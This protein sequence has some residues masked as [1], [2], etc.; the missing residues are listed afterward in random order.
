MQYKLPQIAKMAKGTLTGN[1]NLRVTILLTDSRKLHHPEGVLFIAIRGATDGHNYIRQMLNS[2]VKTFLVEYWPEYLNLPPDAARIKVENTVTALQNIAKEH[3]KQ[4]NIPIIGITG[5]NG[6]TIVKEWISHCLQPEMQVTRNPKSY[7]SQIGV[8]LSVWELS[9]R[10]EIGI[11]EAGISQ[12]CEMELIEAVIAPTIGVFTNIG[13]AHQENFNDKYQ[14]LLEKS[15]LFVNSKTIIT[16]SI[17][18]F[19]VETL[20]NIYPK[21]EMFTWGYNTDDTVKILNQQTINQATL[22][23]IDYKNQQFYCTIPF[24]DNASINNTTTVIGFL[25]Y[26]GYTPQIIQQRINQLQR[27]DMRLEMKEGKNNCTIIDDSY[28]SDIVSLASSLEYLELQHQ[29]PN[30]TVI[31]SDILQSGLPQ[32]TLYKQVAELIRFYS[33][34]LFIGVGEQISKYSELFGDNSIFF[35]TTADL[36]SYFE[37]TPPANTIIL[38]KGSRFFRF[39]EISK[40]LQRKQHR[41]VMEINL[42]AM[43]SNLRYFRSQLNQQTKI[44]VMLKAF[45]YGNGTFELANILQHHKVDYFAVAFTDEGIAL[46][47]SG[48]KI[49]IMVMNPSIETISEIIEYSLEPEIYNFDFLQAIDTYLEQK[50]IINFPVHIKI[51]TGMNRSGFKTN[52]IAALCNSLKNTKTLKTV[53]VFSHLASSDEPL[54]DKFTIKQITEFEG[55]TKQLSQQ[56]NHKFFRHILNS[57]GIERFIQYQFEGVRLGIGLYGISTTNNK[58]IRH[59]ASLKTSIMQ[60]KEV[61][62]CETVGYGLKGKVNKNSKIAIIPIGYADGFRR[63]LGNGNGK[64]W[65]KGCTAPTIG[66]ICMDICMIDVTEIDDVSAGEEVVIFGEPLPLP[67]IASDMNTIPYEVITGISER[68]KRVYYQE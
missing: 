28:N 66:N 35:K 22:I 8:P 55:I 24:T 10:S 21:K 39:E 37:N 14:K 15:K 4:F 44:I 38:L 64:V 58:A 26:F 27:V 42:D 17:D 41:T 36:Y 11:F 43:I 59:V 12:P 7:N 65:I 53:S 52:D 48:I 57:A 19:A 30:K 9:N 67:E 61:N 45:G 63:S 2:G 34:N 5:S 40:L 1:N 18:K 6:K 46:R 33:H 20:K 25:L 13:D 16:P 32:K 68:I 47:K 51:D 31:I 54:H 50:S 62:T 60:I 49:P 3:R 23:N 56:T 29:Q